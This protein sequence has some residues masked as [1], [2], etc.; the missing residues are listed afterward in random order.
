[1]VNTVTLS[2]RFV[3]D[4]EVKRVG[5][6]S[7]AMVRFKLAVE[8]R[9]LQGGEWKSKVNY[10]S[11]LAWGRTAEH[12]G[13]SAAKGTFACLFGRFET[14]SCEKDGKTYYTNDVLVA[15]CD[16]PVAAGGSVQAPPESPAPDDDVPF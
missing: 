14:G 7:T 9:Y 13:R 3:A 10:P 15:E 1:M 11:C 16:I 8:T 2:G 5:A 6:K 4:P 12:I